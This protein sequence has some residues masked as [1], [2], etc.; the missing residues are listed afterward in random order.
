M[1]RSRTPRAD[2]PSGGAERQRRYRQRL[3]AAGRI[4][5]RGIY[6]PRELHPEIRA[7]ARRI[8]SGTAD[9]VRRGGSIR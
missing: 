2:S 8:V 7:A 6:A 1:I 4:E 5:V 9:R 3:K